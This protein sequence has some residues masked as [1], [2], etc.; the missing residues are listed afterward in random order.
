MCFV[1]SFLSVMCANIEKL[2]ACGSSDLNRSKRKLALPIATSLSPISSNWAPI[3]YGNSSL[4]CSKTCSSDMPFTLRLYGNCST[5]FMVYSSNFIFCHYVCSSCEV[6][7]HELN[8][9]KN[10]SFKVAISCML[11]MIGSNKFHV[12][13]VSL[14]ANIFL[15][16]SNVLII[17][18]CVWNA[19]EFSKAVQWFLV[20]PLLW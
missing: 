13:V 17:H 8:L 7:P 10:F 18:C 12:M 15:N 5:S 1:F 11:F 14:N 4:K 6:C 3:F 2:S 19:M 20:V 16:V 9:F